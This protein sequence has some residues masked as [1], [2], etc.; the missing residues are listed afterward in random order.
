MD[1][2]ALWNY[3]R[4]PAFV[5]AENR[6]TIQTGRCSRVTLPS[7]LARVASFGFD[8]ADQGKIPLHTYCTV[9]NF[10]KV[11]GLPLLTTVSGFDSGLLES[12]VMGSELRCRSD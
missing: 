10:R 8:F 11:G 3:D 7:T 5:E 9:A 1:E 2:N 6:R 12:I 4:K